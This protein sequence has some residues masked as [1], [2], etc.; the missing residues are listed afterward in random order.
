MSDSCGG[1][2]A[3][4]W[5]AADLEGVA[6]C[7]VCA[8]TAR[9]VLHRDLADGVFRCAPGKWTLWRCR[10]C[11]AGWLDPRPTPGSV[12]RAYATY[13]THGSG[14]R[15]PRFDNERR[16]GLAGLVQRFRNGELNRSF[17]YR[18]RPAPRPAWLSWLFARLLPSEA[19]R[20][21]RHIRQLPP[22]RTEASRLL[23][24]GAGNGDFLA[25]AAALGYRAE[26]LEFDAQAAA[27][28][29]EAGFPVRVGTVPG[30]ALEAGAY[31]HVTLNHVI[32][33][34]HDPV[35]ALRELYGALAPRG[36][37][38]IQT[39]NL[40]AC[41][42]AEFGANWRGLEPPRH[43]VLFNA[44]ALRAAMERAGFV[45]VVLLRPAPEA[46]SYYR[47]SL[48]IS[49]G[50]PPETGANPHWDRRWKRRA[51]RADRKAR[52]NP[53]RAESI[54]LVGWKSPPGA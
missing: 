51:R 24:V 3:G 44:G 1:A 12:G 29:R 16:S 20:L 27:A 5:P 30:T 28:A 48:A 17:G 34:L 18:R 40:D 15:R 2:D 36:R 25:E 46:K 22:P 45:D 42:H 11:G 33:H 50:V 54:T 49:R 13:Y 7:P 23:D 35:R 53:A 4:E 21:G 37:I 6:A 38:W 9:E 32:E 19:A 31:E 39:P 41:G 8:G 14:R 47:R 43:L 10:S 26:G 52:R